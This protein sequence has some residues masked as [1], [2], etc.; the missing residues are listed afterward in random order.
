MKTQIQ[1]ENLENKRKNLL[2]EVEGLCD[3]EYHLEKNLTEYLDAIA[4]AKDRL[5]ELEAAAR[6]VGI[7]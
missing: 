1:W 2:T 6:A 4:V 3:Q 5:N 7:K